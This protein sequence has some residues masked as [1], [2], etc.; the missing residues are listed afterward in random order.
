MRTPEERLTEARAAVPPSSAVVPATSPLD[1]PLV[2]FQEHRAEREPLFCDADARLEPEAG[3]AEPPRDSLL[4][5]LAA[6]GLNTFTISPA[7]AEGLFSVEAT[8]AAAAQFERD[9]L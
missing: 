9:A 8:E 5:L 1:R 2:R 7:I 4:P 6:E 3:P